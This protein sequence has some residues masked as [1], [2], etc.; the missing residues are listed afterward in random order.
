ML[1][2]NRTGI[3]ST[4]CQHKGVDALRSNQGIALVVNDGDRANMLSILVQLAPWTMMPRLNFPAVPDSASIES[5]DFSPV[6]VLSAIR[7][8]KNKN[9]CGSYGFPPILYKKL[10][11]VLTGSLSLTSLMSIGQMPRASAHAFVTCAPVYKG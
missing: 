2:Y 7:K 6:Q 8:L 1:L 3:R 10:A 5:V 4:E 11:P 9:S